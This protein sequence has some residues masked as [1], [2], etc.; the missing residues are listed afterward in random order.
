MY[1]GAF[2][3]TFKTSS[4]TITPDFLLR[5]SRAPI[6][7]ILIRREEVLVDEFTIKISNRGFDSLKRNE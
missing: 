6:M 7:I 4:P 5:T 1:G 3:L 2:R